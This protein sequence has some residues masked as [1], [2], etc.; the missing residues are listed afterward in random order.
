[1]PNEQ[2]VWPSED[3][4]LEAATKWVASAYGCEIDVPEVLQLKRWGVTASFGS[5]VLKASYTPPFPQVTDI[6]AVLG[7]LMPEGA[8]RLLCSEMVD[9]QLQSN[10]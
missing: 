8:P 4:N 2:L 5:V 9:G 10:E 1:M 3:I 7:Q 6:H